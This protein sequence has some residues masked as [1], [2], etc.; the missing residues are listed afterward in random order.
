MKPLIRFA[1]GLAALIVAGCATTGGVAP[2]RAEI[3]K[4]KD[5]A[6]IRAV[7][8]TPAPFVL[9]SA[10]KVATG[11]LFGIV[12]GAVA[13]NSMQKAGQALIAEYSVADPAAGIRDRLAGA[14][15]S[16][17]GLRATA[18]EAPATDAIP[19]LKTK[20]GDGAVLDT[21]T[22]G[23][24]LIYYPSDWSHH[25][26]VYAGRGRLLRLSDG[27]VLWEGKCFRKLPDEKGSRKTVDDY[28]ANDG[29]LLKQK[30]QEAAD[31][32]ATELL[33]QLGAAS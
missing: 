4:L 6:E 18:A 14:M 28:R 12:G 24:Q 26:L 31:G 1:L 9:M 2:N 5:S 8:Y 13:A 20:F 17:F 21:R 32:C 29:A 11:S 33:A 25:Y 23:W 15:E 22:L 19:D 10:G 30:V 27:K 3:A 7:T 16:H